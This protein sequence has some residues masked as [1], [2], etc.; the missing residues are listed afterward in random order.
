MTDRDKVILKLALLD[1][2]SAAEYFNPKLAE[3]VRDLVERLDN[4]TE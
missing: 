1:Y 4:G 3:E 2:G